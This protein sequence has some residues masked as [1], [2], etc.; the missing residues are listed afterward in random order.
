M[1]P[2][3]AERVLALDPARRELLERRL[4]A[5]LAGG[6]PRLVRRGPGDAPLSF[7]QERLWFLHQLGS[8]GSAYHVPICLEFDGELDVAALRLTLQ[9]LQGRHQVLS[10]AVRERRGEPFQTVVA[11]A[12]LRFE[13]VRNADPGR[14]AALLAEFAARPFDLAEAPLFRS[15]LLETG[16]RSG[17]LLLVFHHL[18]FDGWSIDVL[19]QEFA[20]Q[21]AARRSGTRSEPAELA[22]Q[23]ADYCFWQRA[24]ASDTEL[25]RRAEAWH[26][27][28]GGTAPPHALRLRSQGT[29]SSNAPCGS[30][31][32][33]V[34]IQ[35]L[36]ADLRRRLD[37]FARERSATRFVVSLTAFS[38]ALRAE[39]GIDDI[40]LLTPLANRGLP[41]VAPLI[42]CFAN[43]GLVRADLSGVITSTDALTRVQR[44]VLQAQEF[45]D[46]PFHIL[47]SRLQ[48]ERGTTLNP[49]ACVAFSVQNFARRFELEGARFSV[50][51]V[52]APDVAI[53]LNATLRDTADGAELVIEFSRSRLELASVRDLAIRFVACLE[54][55]VTHADAP[56]GEP[57][58]VLRERECK[59]SR[60]QMLMWLGQAR[61]PEL[62][63][64][65]QQAVLELEGELDVGRLQNAFSRLVAVTDILQ[66]RFIT[67]DDGLRQVFG[68]ARFGTLPLV[69]ADPARLEEISK[70]RATLS[71]CNREP[72]W[73]AVLLETARGRHHLVLTIHHLLIDGHALGE[74]FRRLSEIYAGTDRA[75]NYPGFE[76]YL[77]RD[78]RKHEEGGYCSS[79]T[80]WKQKLSTKPTPLE[81]YG[82]KR[83]PE[84][85]E[86]HS[87]ILP[88]SS[89]RLGRL[90][91]SGRSNGVAGFSRLQTL[92]NV[93]LIGL[94][95]T[96]RRATGVEEHSLGVTLA[97]RAGPEERRIVGPLMS[98][99]VLRSQVDAGR[100][101]VAL[102]RQLLQASAEMMR[103][104]TY[105]VDNPAEERV[106]DVLFNLVS[107]ES[108]SFEGCSATLRLS[109]GSHEYDRVALH[110]EW[111]NG[112]LTLKFNAQK[113]VMGEAELARF[114]AD[115]ERALEQYETAPHSPLSLFSRGD[116]SEASLGGAPALV[117]APGG[118]L[119]QIEF[120][121]RTLDRIA[122]EHAGQ[123]LTYAEL[124]ASVDALSS[125]LAEA[126][127]AP[128]QPVIHLLPRRLQAITA[129][130]AILRAGGVYVPIDPATPVARVRELV[131]R[132][133]ARAAVAEREWA[134][135]LSDLGLH[136]ITPEPE[137]PKKPLTSSSRAWSPKAAYSAGELAYV[138]F[139]SGSSGRPKAVAMSHG[140]LHHFALAARQYMQLGPTDRV[141]QFANLAFDA[142]LEEIF[143]TLTA[144]ATL[145]LRDES[146][147]TGS[148]SFLEFVARERISVLDLP[149]ALWNLLGRELSR[150][151][152]LPDL[153]RLRS[154]VI[155]G[156]AAD[157]EALVGWRRRLPSHV[158]ILNS[159]GPTE[160]CVVS[161][162]HV[163]SARDEVRGSIPLG[164]P[165][166]G[167][168]ISILD[169]AGDPVPRGVCG[170]IYI[171]GSG[172]ARGYWRD[173]GESAKRFVPA[174]QGPPGRLYRT[175]DRGRIND[176]GLLEFRGRQDR[177]VKVRGQRVE[178]A[179]IE[180]QLVRLQ[181][182]RQ[183]A[184]RV[185]GRDAA[186]SCTLV[187]IVERTPSSTLVPQRVAAQ[188][189][190][191]LPS[192]MVPA[193][194]RI[195]DRMPL[196][197]AGKVDHAAL[198]E[199]SRHSAHSEA[200][201]ERALSGEAEHQLARIWA[202][203]LKISPEQIGAE[204]SF[205]DLG[206]H[207]LLGTLL[208]SRI[209]E[210]FGVR[211]PLSALFEA[212]E[213]ASLAER[214]SHSRPSV[215]P[216]AGIPRR[217]G[218]RFPLSSEQRR[219]WFLY[220]LKPEGTEYNVTA[221]VRIRG[222][223]RAEIAI[224]ALRAIVQRHEVLRS[225]IT[226]EGGVPTQCVLPNAALKV[227]RSACAELPESTLIQ[228]IVRAAQEESQR[229]FRLETGPLL[230]ARLLEFGAENHALIVSAHHIVCD[231][232]SVGLLVNE[233]TR[234]YEAA[235]AGSLPE[236]PELAIQYGD[237]AAWQADA[238]APEERR[239]QLEYWQ[240]NLADLP[241]PIRFPLP[242]A[243]GRVNTGVTHFAAIPEDL[244]NAVTR[245][246]GEA[247]ITP[248]MLLIAVWGVLL[249]RWTGSDD[250]LIASP[251][252]ERTRPETHNLIGFFVNTLV[253]RLRIGRSFSIHDVLKQARSVVLNAFNH[254]D[255]PF[256]SV[257]ETLN[258][259]RGEASS[260]LFRVMFTY[261]NEPTRRLLEPTSI[262]W[263]A[264]EFDRGAANRDLT[265]RIEEASG[266]LRAHLEH[267]ASKISEA[268]G[269][270]LLAYYVDVLRYAVD[271]LHARVSDV[272]LPQSLN[273]TRSI[274]EPLP[275]R[276]AGLQ[277]ILK[278]G[279]G[280]PPSTE[281]LV[282]TRNYWPDDPLI[283]LV[284]P[285]APGVNLADW[286]REQRQLVQQRLSEQGA[287]LFR[288]FDVSDA[289]D[290]EAL[291]LAM[292]PRLEEYQQAST[293]RSR[294]RERIYTSTEYPA[295]ES[296]MLHNELSYS[297]C[298]PGKIWFY[299]HTPPAA[300]G[301]TPLAS[302]R[303]LLARLDR[304]V[305][306]AFE[307]KG[308]MYQRNYGSGLD[309][310]WHEVFG[311]QDRDRV[312]SYCRQHDIQWSWL[313]GDR[314]RTLE[315]HKALLRHEHTGEPVWF[316][317]AHMFHVRA[318][319]QATYASLRELFADSDLPRHAYYGDGSPIP[320]AYIEHI[321]D[322]YRAVARRFDWR[323]RDV[324]LVDNVLVAHG[325]EPFSGPRKILVSMAEPQTE[326][327]GRSC[328]QQ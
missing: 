241:P 134:P 324:M 284:T 244:A 208:V 8:T 94:L 223:F 164:K 233:L 73:D 251:I 307:R 77:E 257:Y 219:L 92:A 213:L 71:L 280:S 299:C 70:E 200:A 111:S 124:W 169:A 44:A 49:M 248:Y 55:L 21:Y 183:A 192:Y 194:I 62:P 220:Q 212:P 95:A 24:Q 144:G 115:F 211:L 2:L 160:C 246:A 149:T 20:A 40:G 7:A 289:A 151:G 16:D 37:H 222:S 264:V 15:L 32:K 69:P 47:A 234:T 106:Y 278:R 304:E 230:R 33:V 178:L 270:D 29:G 109:N 179:E 103:H 27:R 28:Q 14:V 135:L 146:M 126:L 1:K 88:L 87:R 260:A 19:L 263:E 161:A 187:A 156:E 67:R 239:A 320:D 236:L 215:A 302:G 199:Q 99:G 155:G 189:R 127:D 242:T 180:A 60:A 301:A 224:Q 145:V 323:R 292:S 51:D 285:R 191:R 31:T 276:R 282:S 296:I 85:T 48:G 43:T 321:R 319:Q 159:Y 42:G 132:M 79:A 174:P 90:I 4:R 173:P 287:I 300:Q 218:A 258:L 271:H 305:R 206:G 136:V 269:R 277:S 195:V 313:G 171:A 168:T 225:V 34:H 177:Q 10:S 131:Q 255:V 197:A 63:L 205:F 25:A 249:H 202:E 297:H 188:L 265:L 291:C 221:A 50:V 245:V 57:P 190:E 326:R 58:A 36:S 152:S 281:Q 61:Y 176:E 105:V 295:S 153:S 316:N 5:R 207:S 41:D 186:G 261:L 93:L 232:W 314:L 175:G 294:V 201:N 89:A 243:P 59:P 154:I 86:I 142:S 247:G 315:V 26:V 38:L 229:P 116:W 252:A 108:P 96:L 286:I 226:M 279:Q 75:E 22:I 148:L 110:A 231:G 141:L 184:V 140:A 18:V 318:H 30:S 214:V 193:E 17:V 53:E 268:C 12:P 133:G 39:S 250:L 35:P 317:S 98:V 309:V 102:G 308:V 267:D 11:D 112:E 76:A 210:T 235:L 150:I 125:Q 303:A 6:G 82:H 273:P 137:A 311:T 130:L 101:F 97:N 290:F 237:Y 172:L 228:A 204:D 81:F 166:P 122:I 74:L 23:Y 262:D 325:R 306:D 310:P 56:L 66:T 162:V 327:D 64:Y 322:S 68:G 158:Q 254:R 182:V 118:L 45:E 84:T 238:L 114:C 196:N 113:H 80:F 165:L 227:S 328:A 170:E 298:W 121:S 272:P 123:A 253:L 104:A 288:G 72:H 203:L 147:L 181:G 216:S 274:P 198:A 120:D 9:A 259:P 91:D 266:Q 83:G 312:E 46:V 240:R 129:I 138:L 293:P 139:T 65:N 3:S 117:G 283:L 13:H 128:E 78:A 143:A 185:G 256:D 167:T 209:E 52:F 119:D 54:R 107:L 163:L 275:S 217:A 100:D 157:H